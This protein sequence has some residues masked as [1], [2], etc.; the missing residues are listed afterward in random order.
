[1]SF[2][3]AIV[4]ILVRIISADAWRLILDGEMDNPREFSLE[5]L[6]RRLFP[7]RERYVYVG[8]RGIPDSTPVTFMKQSRNK[9]R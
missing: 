4:L 5:D 1:M 2:I 6:Q 8:E 3:I 9:H 7:E